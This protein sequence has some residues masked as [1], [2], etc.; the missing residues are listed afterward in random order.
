MKVLKTGRDPKFRIA[1]VFT[2]IFVVLVYSIVQDRRAG[3]LESFGSATKIAGVCLVGCGH[4]GTTF[5]ART[6]SQFPG[7]HCAED[8]ETGFLR[9]WP[10]VP[11]GG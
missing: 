3:D 11:R 1:I 2:S 6:V 10:F 7:V 4:S 8:Y 9:F 5:L